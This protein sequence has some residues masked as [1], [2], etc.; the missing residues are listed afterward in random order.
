MTVAVQ[1]FSIP[2]GDDMDV[3]FTVDPADNISLVGATVTWQA[4]PMS[5]AVPATPPIIIKSSAVSGEIT[6]LDSPGN[7]IVHLL[8]ADT[9]ALYCGNYYHEAEILDASQYR[10]TV[11][12]GAMAVTLALIP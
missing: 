8:A 7:F 1:A 12:Q 11:C 2:Q 10:A 3:G 5:Y 9:A 4:F 6:V